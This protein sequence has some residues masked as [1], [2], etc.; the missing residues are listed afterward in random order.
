MD[1]FGSAESISLVAVTPLQGYEVR[2]ENPGVPSR[3]RN[4]KSKETTCSCILMAAI[5]D[6]KDEVKRIA[7]AEEGAIDIKD[8]RGSSAVHYA[9]RHNNPRV[10]KML[11]DAGADINLKG[12]GGQTPLYTTA[13]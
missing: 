1:E 6:L 8:G 5:E 4:E 10:I 7:S 12:P 2:N 9:A 13:R 11:L 3:L